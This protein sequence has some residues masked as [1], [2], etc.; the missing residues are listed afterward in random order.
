MSKL[1]SFKEL[2]AWQKAMELVKQV[3]TLTRKFPK[4]EIYGLTSQMR[5]SAVSIPC[6]IAEGQARNSTGEFKQFLGISKGSLAETETLLILSNDLNLISSL[7]L[8][9]ITKATDE[10]GKLLNGL[11]NSLKTSG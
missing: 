2:I 7:E 6:N 10:V 4:E 8:E 11:L 1:K 9:I 5:R 3:Y